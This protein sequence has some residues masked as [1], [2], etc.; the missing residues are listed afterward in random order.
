MRQTLSP[1]AADGSSEGVFLE[2][3][4]ANDGKPHPKVPGPAGDQREPLRVRQL[5]T[6]P[7]QARQP[8]APPKPLKQPKHRSSLPGWIVSG[9]FGRV[10]DRIEPP[11]PRA[12]AV[13]PPA[14]PAKVDAY[15]WS[16]KAAELNAAE[17]AATAAE[18]PPASPGAGG[19]GIY[20]RVLL[21]GAAAVLAVLLI[22]RALR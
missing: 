17:P 4:L 6:K 21:V 10:E 7:P 9:R 16:P 14:A 18:G 19:F 1:P 15:E 20:V 12:R 5:P 3:A 2:A 13:K 8:A 11:T 22:V